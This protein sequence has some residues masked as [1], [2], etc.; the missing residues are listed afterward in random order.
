MKGQVM[1]KNCSK[2]CFIAVILMSFCM[3]YTGI[4]EDIVMENQSG[5]K[6]IIP[7]TDAGYTLGSISLQGKLIESPL[8][9]GMIK[10]K[11]TRTNTVTWKI[12]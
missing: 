12:L 7:K 2:H 1:T 11:N 3:I 8:L 10:V 6:V 9:K 5:V 4:A